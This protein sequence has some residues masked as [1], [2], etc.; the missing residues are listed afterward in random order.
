MKDYIS[1]LLENIDDNNS[2]RCKI[3]EY[4]Q[5]R[6][7]Q[8]LQEK[9]AFAIWA[10][11]GGTAL[12]FLYSLPRFSEDLDFSLVKPGLDDGFSDVVK[13][14]KA[15]FEAEGYRVGIKANI[16]KNVKSAFVKFE[17]LLFEL[18]Y[19]PHRSE[20]ISIKIELDTNPPEGA[21]V[22]STIIR[23]YMILNIQ[24]YDKSALLAGKLHALLARKYLK[25]RD[26]Y[27]LFWYLS[28]KNWPEPNLLLLNN[29]LRQTGWQGETIIPENWKNILADKVKSYN[30]KRVIEDV[31]PFLERPEELR[32]LNQENFIQLLSG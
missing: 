10:F 23:K 13:A 5:A 20:V 12:R 1:Q 19:S 21:N 28:D 32:L 3:R 30:W 9:T 22:V 16:K 24:H 27:D 4:L 29:A 25:G 8:V 11:L 31:R 15:V 18:G 14:I 7:L 6:V 2:G 17:G 26:V